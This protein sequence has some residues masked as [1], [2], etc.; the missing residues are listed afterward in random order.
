MV[1]LCPYWIR[2]SSSYVIR[3]KVIFGI[4]TTE[5]QI[6]KNHSEQLDFLTM[7]S[8]PKDFKFC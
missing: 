7:H 3:R 6:F 1:D 8:D 2:A 4:F 5:K